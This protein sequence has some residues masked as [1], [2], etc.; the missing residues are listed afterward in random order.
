MSTKSS[1]LLSFGLVT[2]NRRH[3]QAK[4]GKQEEG[5]QTDANKSQIVRCWSRPYGPGQ[6]DSQPDPAT[7]AINP[8]QQP[9]DNLASSSKASSPA[10]SLVLVQ[11]DKTF[12]EVI[13]GRRSPLKALAGRWGETTHCK[14]GTNGNGFQP[15]RVQQN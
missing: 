13:R 9:Y 12:L 1:K 4:K 15:I 2:S 5:S 8:S 11:R 10:G 6:T 7:Q 14:G 3:A